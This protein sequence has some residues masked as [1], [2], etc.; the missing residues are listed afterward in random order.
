MRCC[1]TLQV[2]THISVRLCHRL[3]FQP[4]ERARHPILALTYPSALHA[5]HRGSSM[6]EGGK[7]DKYAHKR[8]KRIRCSRGVAV[9]RAGK[10]PPEVVM[11]TCMCRG[12]LQCASALNSTQ[13][14]SSA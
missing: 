3:L 13:H 4:F 1:T 8:G 7:C 11:T 9:Q 6:R 12:D 5:Q 2:G 14:A 10:K